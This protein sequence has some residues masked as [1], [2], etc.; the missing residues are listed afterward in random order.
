MITKRSH[1]GHSTAQL[2]SNDS[3]RAAYYE[4][5]KHLLYL[6][7]LEPVSTLYLTVSLQIGKI[8][9]CLHNRQYSNSC[10]THSDKSFSKGVFRFSEPSAKGSRPP[11]VQYHLF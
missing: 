4:T 5:G 7:F 2:I 1:H 8:L 9:P 6:M 11:K 10:H 3:A